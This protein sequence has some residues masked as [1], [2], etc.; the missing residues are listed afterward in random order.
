MGIQTVAGG[1][2]TAEQVKE[3]A[4]FHLEECLQTAVQGEAAIPVHHRALQ[5]AE[6]EERQRPQTGREP[7][8]PGHLLHWACPAEASD[9]K[10]GRKKRTLR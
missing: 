1:V 2:H 5:E 7:Q 4:L 10:G 3:R 9:K 6:H 8:L